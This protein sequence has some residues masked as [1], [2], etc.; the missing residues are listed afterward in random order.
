[1]RT[2][3]SAC[4]RV[5]SN[6]FSS[7]A[8]QSYVHG[9]N[10]LIRDRDGNLQGSLLHRLKLELAAVFEASLPPRGFAENPPHGLACRS[11]ELCAIP[12]ARL[13]IRAESKPGFVNTRGGL[14]GVA[15]ILTRHFGGS[16]SSQLAIDERE[17]FLSGLG[18]A[19]LGLIENARDV[20]HG[21]GRRD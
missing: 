4:G 12:P 10:L 11:G 21:P 17:Q 2:A 3:S 8:L 7:E 18:V 13:L 9:K 6:C 20:T 14:Q 15:G 19:L 1:M 16:E 5:A